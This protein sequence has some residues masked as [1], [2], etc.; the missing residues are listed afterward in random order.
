MRLTSRFLFKDILMF[1]IVVKEVM[2]LVLSL[3]AACHIIDIVYT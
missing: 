2:G 3:S 1:D